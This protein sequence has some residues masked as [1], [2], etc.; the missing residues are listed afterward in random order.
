MLGCVGYQW[1]TTHLWGPQSKHAA[2]MHCMPHPLSTACPP[3]PASPALQGPFSAVVDRHVSDPWLRSLLDLECFVLSGMLARDTLTAEMAFMFMERSRGRGRIDYPVS[4]WGGGGAAGAG[5]SCQ[6]L[7][8]GAG[9][10]AHSL[11]T[12]C[13]LVPF[14]LHR[15]IPVTQ[16]DVGNHS[17]ALDVGMSWLSS[18]ADLCWPRGACP[19]VCNG[20]H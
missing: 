17:C 11:H 7:E 16:L 9:R 1:E 5:C 4:P 2:P 6:C 18:L 3:P 20:E 19:L 13:L 15:V 8:R 10:W 12:A 14:Q